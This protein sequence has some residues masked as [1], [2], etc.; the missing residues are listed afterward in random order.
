MKTQQLNDITTK[1]SNSSPP[2]MPIASLTLIAHGDFE[3]GSAKAQSFKSHQVSS[4]ITMTDELASQY[5]LKQRFLVVGPAN[6]QSDDYSDEQ[7]EAANFDE[8]HQDMSLDQSQRSS[9]GKPPKKEARA[10]SKDH[11]IMM[12]MK[13]YLPSLVPKKK[14]RKVYPPKA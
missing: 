1:H 8:Q 11:K 4:G 10:Y 7:F 14:N 2:C 5:N 3:E 12:T 13:A 9:R 6:N